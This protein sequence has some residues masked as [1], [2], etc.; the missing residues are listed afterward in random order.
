MSPFTLTQSHQ[1]ALHHRLL[2][3]NLPSSGVIPIPNLFPESSRK[4][5][6]TSAP[7]DCWRCRYYPLLAGRFSKAEAA[8]PA[9]SQHCSIFTPDPH[10][11]LD[12]HSGSLSALFSALFKAAPTLLAWICVLHDVWF[13]WPLV[14]PHLTFSK[15]FW[16]RLPHYPGH[17][18]KA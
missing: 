9:Q 15:S 6:A 8:S 3:Y 4:A 18:L 14:L 7:S 17:V 13:A 2:H 12:L 5:E 1:A 11:S 16:S 10:V